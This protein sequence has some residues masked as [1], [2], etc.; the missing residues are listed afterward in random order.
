MTFLLGVLITFWAVS[1]W[2]VSEWEYEIDPYY[3]N[4]AYYQTLD[5][6]PVP[7][8]GERSEAQVYSDSIL[9]NRSQSQSYACS[10]CFA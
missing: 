2:A 1:A 9:L 10:R 6:S 4:V 7:E 5:D 8:L 3:S